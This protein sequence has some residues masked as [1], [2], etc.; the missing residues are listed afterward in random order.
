MDR[1]VALKTMAAGAIMPGLCAPGETP[2]LPPGVVKDCCDD[3]RPFVFK[4]GCAE[5]RY[6]DGF[7]LKVPYLAPFCPACGCIKPGE[8]NRVAKA[9]D[10]ASAKH[11]RRNDIPFSACVWGTSWYNS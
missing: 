4:R 8:W 11:G 9:L 1:R 6:P 2:A 5:L 7:R 3:K 10:K